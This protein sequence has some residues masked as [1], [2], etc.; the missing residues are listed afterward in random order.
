MVDSWLHGTDL[1][2]VERAG[3]SAKVVN[4]LKVDRNVPRRIAAGK[5]IHGSDIDLIE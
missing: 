4:E 1:F 3:N 2:R 5:G